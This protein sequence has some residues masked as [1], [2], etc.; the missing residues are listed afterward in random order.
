MLVLTNATID[1]KASG[2]GPAS[3]AIATSA[4]TYATNKTVS[5][6]APGSIAITTM[7][8]SMIELRVYGWAATATGGTLRLQNTLVV[9]GEL[10]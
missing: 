8:S 7:S 10:R 3:G 9:D 4:D 5:T 1:A 2:T 6:A